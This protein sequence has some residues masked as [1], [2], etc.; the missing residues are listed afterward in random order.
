MVLFLGL[1]FYICSVLR[2]E[3][4]LGIRALMSAAMCLSLGGI[5]WLEHT[6]V[7]LPFEVD[8]NLFAKV[9]YLSFALLFI[10]EIILSYLIQRTF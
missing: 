3:S 8:I 2:K 7:D 9:L 10:L 6:E 4:K 1:E 5:W